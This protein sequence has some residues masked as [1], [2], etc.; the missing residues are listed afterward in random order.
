MSDNNKR[1]PNKPMGGP[2]PGGGPGG[3]GG[4]PPGMGP[5]GKADDFKG[6]LKKLFKYA[7][8]Y[9]GIVL[10][11]IVLSIISA[12]CSLLGPDELSKITNLIV[13]GMQ[14]GIDLDEV[15]EI[16]TF[17][18]I[19]Y[20]TSLV[21]GYAQSSIMATISHSLGKKLRSDLVEKLN[22][23]PL[24]YFDKNSHGDTLSNVTND[25]DTIGT[26]LNQSLST[27][28]SGV[29][30]F[31][32]ALF[33]MFKTNAIMA[34]SA[35]LSTMIGFSL[36]G[37]IIKSSQKHFKAQQAQLGG[38]NG[39]IEEIY[40][41]HI[42]VKAYNN[43][44]NAR[45]EFSAN[46]IK[47]Q[48]AA[49]KAQYFS[50]LMMP[51]MGFVGNFA[52][53]IICIVGAVLAL[54]GDIDFGVIVAFTIY[55]RLFT[56]PL[57][58]LAQAATTLQSAAAASERVF[59]LLEEEELID[60][61]S[62]KPFKNSVRGDV[63]FKDIKFGYN[64]DKLIIKGFSVD[65]K[66]GQKVA[67]VGPTGAG[68]TTLVNLLMRFYELNSGEIIIDNTPI[69]EMTREDLHDIFAMVLQDTW[70]FEGSVKDNII[71]NKDNITEQDVIN[72][73]KSVGVHHTIMT[74][75]KGYDTIMSG[76]SLSVGEKQLIT[77]ARAMVKRADLLILD[78]AT[79]SVDTRT[80]I[81]IQ[82]ALDKLSNGKTSF[83]IAHRLSTIKNSDVILVMKEGNIIESGNHDELL[84]QNGFYAE[85]YN[86]Q[87]KEE[88]E[89]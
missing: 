20:A 49:S 14:G 65:I 40:T 9:T 53:V 44:E 55:V 11:A 82:E 86:S 15:Q 27:I 37:F 19:L 77:I 87:F 58:N 69:S 16:G 63:E 45:A 61:T 30:T 79:S 38:L 36:M 48:E 5:G 70:I 75:P 64:P 81:L 4:G 34:I 2:P 7:N 71:Y 6:S 54:N 52:Y 33:L 56:Q 25:V 47:L 80:E 57:A 41:G 83:I 62:K 29:F 8:N 22:K 60:E 13:G 3:P 35:V 73:C 12:T 10:F 59:N 32:G 50:G 84:S 26:S 1:P 85:L 89:E 17:L 67:I 21:C 74:L 23:L 78:E 43:E 51:I 31:V 28:I 18:F 24:S 39:H 66:A 68:K 46:N 76:S 72:A 88:D 42:I